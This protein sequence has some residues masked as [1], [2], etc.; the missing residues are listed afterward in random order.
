M[1]H[2]QKLE[3]AVERGQE[4]TLMYTRVLKRRLVYAERRE[5]RQIL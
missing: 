4:G 2:D 1:Q 5:W 3:D